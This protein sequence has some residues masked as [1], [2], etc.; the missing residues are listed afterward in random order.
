LQL[1]ASEKAASL[2]PSATAKHASPHPAPSR[3]RD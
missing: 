2:T 1:F 3:T